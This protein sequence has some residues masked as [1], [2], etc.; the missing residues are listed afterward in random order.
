MQYI[1][2]SD[3]ATLAERERMAYISGNTAEAAML[4]HIQDTAETA[5]DR[6]E[7]DSDTWTY[8]DTAE[9]AADT[10]AAIL[11][12]ASEGTGYHRGTDYFE[13]LRASKKQDREDALQEMFEDIRTQLG[14][15]YAELHRIKDR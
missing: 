14:T 6:E 10:L 4:A 8:A 11:D 1:D 3:T 7:F 13:S 9:K 15:I 2:L 12:Y 5:Q